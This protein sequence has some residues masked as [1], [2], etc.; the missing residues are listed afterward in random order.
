MLNLA[1]DSAQSVAVFINDF[2]QEFADGLNKLASELGR[3]LKGVI[4]IDTE[5][6]NQGHNVADKN[7]VFES[8]VCDFSSPTSIQA[9]L[10][11]FRDNILLATCSSERNQPYL[12]KLIP[13]IPYVLEPTESSLEWA[14]HKSKMR[15][16]LASY[17]PA[18]TPKVQDVVNDSGEEI[19]KVLSRLSFPMIAKPT[20]LASSMLVSKAHNQKELTQ[21]LKRSFALID[22]IYA[23]DKGRGKPSMIVEE[24][25]EGD[26][27]SVDAYVTHAGDVWLLPFLRSLTAHTIGQEGFHIHQ[28]NSNLELD[29]KAIESGN[30]AA[31]QAIHALALRSCVVH[32]ELFY[33]SDGWK[34]IELGPRAGGQRQEM[35]YTAYGIDHAYNELRLK[36]GLVPEINTIPIAHSSAVYF[37]ADEE[38]VI[39]RIEGFEESAARP[40]TYKLT[41][42]ANRGDVAVSSSNGG[43]FIVR[44]VIHHTDPSQLQRDVDTLRSTIKIHTK[45]V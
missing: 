13:H 28:V 19:Q 24:F 10:K 20:G 1:N 25:I 29:A 36:I 9:A 39:D 14:T 34:I 22:I 42:H 26:M 8:V 6:I 44:G 5:V 40:S 27:Y 41:L 4:L 45:K 15:E 18:L 17:N 16:M 23:R 33:T 11:P 37:Y 3:P 12:A 30:F 43:K 35:Y 31:A 21:V 7:K 2:D 32:L 38:G